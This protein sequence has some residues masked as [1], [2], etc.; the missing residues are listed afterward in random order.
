MDSRTKSGKRVIGLQFVPRNSVGA[1]VT[2]PIKGTIVRNEKPLKTEYCI[3]S[4][5]GKVDVVW[6]R[7]PEDD[8]IIPEGLIQFE[9]VA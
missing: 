2:Y 5:D 6:N 3:W 1:L 8:L 7:C 4:V 9:D